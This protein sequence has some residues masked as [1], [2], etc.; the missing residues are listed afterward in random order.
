[1]VRS[2]PIIDMLE[3]VALGLGELKKEVVFVGGAIASLY[4]VDEGVQ[5]IRPTVDIDCVIAITG[6]SSYY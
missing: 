5:R 2:S 3:E 4:I 6:R 1:M